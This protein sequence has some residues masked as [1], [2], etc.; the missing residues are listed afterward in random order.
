MLPLDD[1]RWSRLS[2]AYG[3]ATDVPDMLRQL[4]V[5]AEQ[6]AGE[7]SKESVVLWARLWSCLCHQET[8]FDAS[9][10]AVPHIVDIAIRDPHFS[11]RNF[12]QLPAEIDKARRNGA[13][14]PLPKELE[15][16]YLE[17]IGRLPRLRRRAG[18]KT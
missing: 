4:A 5:L 17:A 8:A 6:N 2:H 10:A 16:A 1:P 12:R 3:D 9:Y 13:G 14:P 11:D 7:D 15:A 18:N